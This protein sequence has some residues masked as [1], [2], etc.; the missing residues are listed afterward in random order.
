MCTL[1]QRGGTYKVDDTRVEELIR[2]GMG[3]VRINFSHVPKMQYGKIECF[4]AHVRDVEKKTKIPIPIM[5]DLKGPEIRIRRITARPPSDK[6]Q[7]NQPKVPLKRGDFVQFYQRWKPNSVGHPKVAAYAALEFEGTFAAIVN[8]DDSVVAGD[9]DL[10]L[11]VIAK[12]PPTSV[13]CKVK[14]TGTLKKGHSLN[15][16]EHEHLNVPPVPRADRDAI[17]HGFDIDLIA[18][19]FVQSVDDIVR[20][21]EN[22]TQ[23]KRKHIRIIAKIETQAAFENIDD[24]LGHKLVYGIMVARGDLGVL[25]PYRTIPERQVRLVNTANKLG[26]PV[27]VATQLLESMMNRPTPY[28]SEVQDIWTAVREGADALMLSGETAKGNY[29]VHS[30]SVM[31]DVVR[32]CTPIDQDEYLRKFDGK[33]ALPTVSRPIDA[34]GFA[35]CEVAKEANA[36]VI[37]SYATEGRSATRISRC[38]P[39]SPIVTITTSPRTAR[40]LVLLY[41]VYPVFVGRGPSNPL[42]RQ[43]KEFIEFIWQIISRE[44]DLEDAIRSQRKEVGTFFL[45]GTEEL[46]KLLNQGGGRGK[47]RGIFVFEPPPGLIPASTSSSFKP[48]A[49]RNAP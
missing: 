34:L 41:N 27:I 3:I 23:T 37:F 16:P 15:L 44:Q 14:D 43:P 4:I 19:S 38:R 49:A 9:N 33:Y 7:K 47:A 42:P 29:P 35:I 48:Q 32:E 39:S 26:K 12:D 18:Q 8:P 10:F 31:R 24:I 21:H 13:V 6:N 17:A 11:E 28:R 45:V 1:T 22:L 2:E 20:L 25:V 40:E 46:T 5:M 30:V 36:P